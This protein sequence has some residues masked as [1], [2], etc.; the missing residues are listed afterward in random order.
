[1]MSLAPALVLLYHCLPFCFLLLLFLIL[2]IFTLFL[3]W[4]PGG[5]HITNRSLTFLSLNH[6]VTEGNLECNSPQE[7]HLP[8][9]SRHTSSFTDGKSR[10]NWAHDWQCFWIRSF[11]CTLIQMRH[12]G[13][14]FVISDKCKCLSK[15]IILSHSE[16]ECK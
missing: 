14:A 1:M 13:Q 2:P 8:F 4:L 16:W 3:Y 10:M 11:Y 12:T 6:S 7:L 15:V 5:F 9:L